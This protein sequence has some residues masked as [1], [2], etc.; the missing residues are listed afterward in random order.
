MV[1]CSQSGNHRKSLTSELVQSFAAKANVVCC[2]S[3][4]HRK[5]FTPELVQSC[6]TKA[7]GRM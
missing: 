4:N 5:R 3:R 6:A 7:N 2:Q 1:V